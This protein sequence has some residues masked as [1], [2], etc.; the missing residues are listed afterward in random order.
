M[1]NS[2]FLAKFWGWYLLIFFLIL[3]FNPKRIK[4]IF[5]DLKDQKF[6]IIFSFVAIIIGLL[7]V[8]FHNIWVLNYK[9]IITL[10]GWCALFFGLSLFMFPKPTVYWLKIINIR[11]VQ[12]I[13]TLLFFL[14]IFLLNVAYNIVPL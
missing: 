8:L 1:G 12:V 6:L 14:G 9:L 2:I 4:Q 10:I 13:Y 3:S 7:N 11:M 5:N